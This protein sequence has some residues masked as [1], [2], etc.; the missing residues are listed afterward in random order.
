M[1]PQTYDRDA[2]RKAIEDIRDVHT[3]YPR[4][5]RIEK[6]IIDLI[7][8][9]N[10]TSEGNIHALIGPSRSG[11]SHLLD[12]LLVRYP[13]VKSAFKG[14]DGDFSDH[15][16][17]VK[18]EAR[19]VTTKAMAQ[20][21]YEALTG[22]HPDAIFGSRYT[23]DTVVKDIIRIAGECRTKLLILDEV[24]ELIDRKTDK[25]VANVA[26]LIKNLVNA[27]LFSILLVGTT[28]AD[29]L[30][31]ADSEMES[32]T[33]VIYRMTPFETGSPEDVGIWLRVPVDR[34]HRFRWILITRSV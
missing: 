12:G 23:E 15:I 5:Q 10:S 7:N 19:N 6:G 1:A 25:V 2:L 11:K 20:R 18:A 22:S 34:D 31:H 4:L 17:V 27:K 26:V 13:T 21:I 3:P 24:H 32:R 16:P 33:P 8:R 9:G 28:K 30:I 29:D 14:A